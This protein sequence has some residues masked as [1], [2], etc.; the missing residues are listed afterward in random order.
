MQSYYCTVHIL[1]STPVAVAFV[2]AFSAIL[3]KVVVTLPAA[4]LVVCCFVLSSNSPTQTQALLKKASLNHPRAAKPK[5]P[6]EC[7]YT[8]NFYAYHMRPL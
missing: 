7:L 5:V 4:A 8:T 1:V 3:V 2:A 6:H